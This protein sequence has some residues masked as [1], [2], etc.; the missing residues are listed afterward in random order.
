MRPATL[1]HPQSVRMRVVASIAAACI[2]ALALTA[3]TSAPGSHSTPTPT[4]GHGLSAK[5]AI[6]KI[7]ATGDTVKAIAS[8]NGTIAAGGQDTPS[9][10][11]ADILKVEAL[12]D[13][14]VL[15]WR[16][17]S[18]N[19]EAAA[20]N[21]FQVSKPPFLDTRYIGLVDGSTKKI[22]YAYTYAPANA[23]DGADNGC[24]C[25]GIPDEVGTPGTV[26]HS[27]MPPLPSSLTTVDVTIPGFEAITGVTVTRG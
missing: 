27:V 25:S 11:V 3:C 15:T 18:A 14:T 8:A 21:S 23:A 19:G 7:M 17:K 2:A 22:Y 9:A 24:L 16:L 20:T 10:V 6:A 5:E 12:P 1:A 13:S 4:H 26:L